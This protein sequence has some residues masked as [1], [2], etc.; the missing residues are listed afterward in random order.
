MEKVFDPAFY[1]QEIEAAQHWLEDN[2]LALSVATLAQA[3][4]IGLAFLGALSVAT[5]ERALLVRPASGRFEPQI[6]HLIE[7]LQPLAKPLLWLLILW[8]LVL[9]AST[10]SLPFR[11]MRTVASLLTAWVVIRFTASLVR[12]PTWSRFVAVVVWAIAALSILGLLAPTMAAFDSVAITLSDLRISALTVLEAVL[13]LALLLWIATVVGRVLERRITASTNLTPSLQ[14]LIVKLVKIV[15]GV[16]AVLVALRTVGIDL[17]GFTVLTGAIG[18]GIG[19]GLQKIISNFVGGITILLDKSIK[20]GDV[21]VVGNTH[22]QVNS[23][24]ARYVSVITRDGT[25]FLIPN[26]TLVTEQVVNWSYSSQQIRLKA[27]IGISYRSD[28]RRAIAL[29]V[30]AAGMVERVLKQPRPVCLLMGFG[31]NSVDLELRFWIQDPMA[32]VSN[33]KSE[34]L[35]HVWDRFHANDIEIP[36]PQ[37]DLHI[38]TPMEVTVRGVEEAQNA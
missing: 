17:T 36:F 9:L 22:G 24:G 10:A 28:V 32:G 11:L 3:L 25:E 35:L 6:A 20:P 1:T 13:S 26:E 38:K 37:H 33:V 8:L 19:F 30:E 16:I 31:A 34:V 7:A 5:R 27:P 14:V 18:V 29:C 15:L 23:L 4:V 12:D 21:L 2:A